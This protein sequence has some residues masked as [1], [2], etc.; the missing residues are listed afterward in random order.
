MREM[1]KSFRTERYVD[2]PFAYK[3]LRVKS[4]GICM[5]IIVV[6]SCNAQDSYFGFFI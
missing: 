6:F 2:S 5:N 3:R 4:K 1:N